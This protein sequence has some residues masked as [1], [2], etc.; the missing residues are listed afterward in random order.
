VENCPRFIDKPNTAIAA[1]DNSRDP[2][3]TAAPDDGGNPMKVVGLH[4]ADLNRCVQDAQRERVV[5]TRRGKPVAILMGIDGLD[6]EQVE[7]GYSEAF[8]KLIR[9]RRQQQTVSR[10][11]LEKRLTSTSTKTTSRREKKQKN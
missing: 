10:A 2:A 11:E 9:E 3:Q 5:L 1:G 7:L 4:E 8:W 6:L